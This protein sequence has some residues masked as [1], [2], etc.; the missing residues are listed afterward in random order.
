MRKLS[1]S[2]PL[3]PDILEPNLSLVFCGTAAGTVSA[4]RGAYY[5]HPHNKFWK[6]LHRV[7]LTPR[8]L[9]PS[10]YNQLPEWGLGLTDIAKT[11]CGMDKELPPG[12]LGELACHALAER[13]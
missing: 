7:G 9:D 13:I 8:L 1:L 3:L 10:E 12:S 4:Q 6:T 5:A 2:S 11:V